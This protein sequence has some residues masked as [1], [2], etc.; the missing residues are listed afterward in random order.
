MNQELR[1][2]WRIRKGRI[3]TWFGMDG[4]EDG[5]DLGLDRVGIWS[6]LDWVGIWTKFGDGWMGLEIWIGLDWVG[7]VS[8]WRIDWLG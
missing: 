2:K 7:T 1:L 6:G 8:W 3:W 4:F 5:W